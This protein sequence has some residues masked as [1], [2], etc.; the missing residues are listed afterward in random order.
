MRRRHEISTAHHALQPVGVAA[1]RTVACASLE[2]TVLHHP[3]GQAKAST[4]TLMESLGTAID[5]AFCDVD[6]VCFATA[7]YRALRGR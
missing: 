3:I 1:V 2:L 4:A 7:P 6:V 5:L